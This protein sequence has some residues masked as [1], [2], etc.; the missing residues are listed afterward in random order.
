MSLIRT[1][2]YIKYAR[3]N[4]QEAE[5]ALAESR[6]ERCASKVSYAHTALLKAIAAALPT[7]RKDFFK[8]TDK[9]LLRH[10]SDL[11]DREDTAMEIVSSL[12]RAKSAC[13]EYEFED[14]DLGSAGAA[15]SAAGTAFSLIHDLFKT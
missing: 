7:V 6:P 3:I 5:A 8:M 1:H 12:S 11:S 4:L 15:L 9:E 10:V 13:R 14:S 2:T